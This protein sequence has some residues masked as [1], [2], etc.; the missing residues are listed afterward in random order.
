MQWIQ[1]CFTYHIL[2]VF[3]E[4]YLNLVLSAIVFWLCSFYLWFTVCVYTIGF[5]LLIAFSHLCIFCIMWRPGN[6]VELWW[7]L[8]AAVVDCGVCQEC[9]F[10]VWQRFLNLML[11]MYCC[12][13]VSYV[14]SK[15]ILLLQVKYKQKTGFHSTKVSYVH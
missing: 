3:L 12:P 4:S 2:Q 13:H 10:Q 14:P 1:Q 11:M 9:N 5:Y 15:S 6:I 7:M 8:T